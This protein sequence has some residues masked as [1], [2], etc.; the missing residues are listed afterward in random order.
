MGLVLITHDL[1][2][3]FAMCDRIYVLY[4]G[5]LLEIAPAAELEAEPL[6]P[7]S[8]GLLLSEPPAD[9]R[10]RDLVSIPGSVP[11]PDAGRRHRARSRRAAGGPRPACEQA[12]PPLAEVAATWP[13]AAVRLRPAARDP[14]RDGLAARAGRAGRGHAAA[15]GGRRHAAHPGDATSAE[16]LRTG[17][18]DGHRPRRRVGRGRRGRV[19]RPGRRVRLGQD[20]AGPG[21]GRPGAA[22]R[23]GRSPSTASRPATGAS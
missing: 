10:V 15:P 22:A 1:R 19:G 6:H 18:P 8:H 13:R 9:H 5:S 23:A 7:Y 4:A 16:G 14:G 17:Q 20:H 21:A 11:A 12:A 3:A 2:V